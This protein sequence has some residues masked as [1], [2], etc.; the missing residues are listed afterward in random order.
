MAVEV[1]ERELK[2]RLL[3]AQAGD[4]DHM[5]ECVTGGVDHSLHL[6]RLQARPTCQHRPGMPGSAEAATAGSSFSQ[7]QLKEGAVE[8]QLL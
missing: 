7:G 1:V 5:P 3:R 4:E 2:P 6:S 8:K